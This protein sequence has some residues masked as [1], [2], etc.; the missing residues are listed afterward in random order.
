MEHNREIL[1]EVSRILKAG[2]KYPL[3]VPLATAYWTGMTLVTTSLAFPAERNKTIVGLISGL[4]KV[5]PPDLIDQG[6][7]D[8][9]GDLSILVDLALSRNDISFIGRSVLKLPSGRRII[10]SLPIDPN[11]RAELEG[12]RNQ[13]LRAYL[14]LSDEFSK[15]G[16]E[17]DLELKKQVE[18]ELS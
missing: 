12:I 11:D 1:G 7:D 16:G 3:R 9:Q 17:L 4:E 10:E 6:V 8:F 2:R 5:V 18:E 15:K 14:T 13:Q